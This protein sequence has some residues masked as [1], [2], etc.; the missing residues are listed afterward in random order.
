MP[1]PSLRDWLLWRLVFCLLALSGVSWCVLHVLTLWWPIKLVLHWIVCCNSGQLC[2]NWDGPEQAWL[3]SCVDCIP[4]HVYSHN[5]Q[6]WA[7]P[8]FNSVLLLMHSPADTIDN[9]FLIIFDTVAVATMLSNSLGYL[10]QLRELRTFH[11]KSLTQV[12]IEQ[13]MFPSAIIG[14][15]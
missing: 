2:I 7:F 1:F 10:R 15:S 8:R 5:F 11:T 6:K 9:I 12:V 14:H 13:S 3:V 4:S